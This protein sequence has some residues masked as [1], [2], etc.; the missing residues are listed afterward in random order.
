MIKD[1][2]SGEEILYSKTWPTHFQ[3]KEL[4][5]VAATSIGNGFGVCIRKKC[6]DIIGFYDELLIMGQD[7]DFLFRLVRNFDFETIPEVLVK[8]H[9]HGPS[10]LTNERNNLIR[11]ELREKI[12]ERHIDLL[13]LYP[14]LYYIHY[15]HI[16]DLCYNLKL[17]QKGR[18]TM[19]S[20]IKNSSFRFLNY[21]DLLSYE[22]TGKDTIDFYIGSR[23]RKLIHFIK[24]KK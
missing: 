17:K 9:K 14:K 8:I 24:R 3:T 4:G 12:L 23:L 16:A 2:V 20:I 21:T 22:L 10:Q 15:K 5:L 7:T 18:K 1:T 13:K 6:I 19:F 11:F